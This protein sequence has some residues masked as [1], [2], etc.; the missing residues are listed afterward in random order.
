MNED[1][2]TSTTDWTEEQLW[3]AVQQRDARF[4]GRM[5]YAVRSTGIYCKPTCPS[6]RPLR[7]NVFFFQTI[8]EADAAGFRPC[9]R[10]HPEET[11]AQ[12]EQVALARRACA[13][14]DASPEQPPSLEVLS[15]EL[16]L[17]PSYLQ[18]IFKSVLG[19]SPRQ[20]AANQKL[21]AFK[22]HI[23]AGSDVTTAMYAAGYSSTSRLYE[24]VTQRMG[25]TPASYRQGG[26]GKQIHFTF[27]QTY[28]G[29]ML[30][31][32]T[33]KG[34]CRVSF[35]QDEPGMVTL[36]RTE[37]PAAELLQDDTNLAA[38]V[39]MLVKH[40]EGSQ[41]HLALPLDLQATAFQLRVWEE[42]R[43]IPYGQTRTYAEVAQAVGKPRAVRAVANACAA[44]PVVVVTPCHRVVRSDGSLG[45]YRYGVE[46]KQA[47]LSQEQDHLN[48]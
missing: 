36:L 33:D 47:L 46:R 24:G 2:L 28:L 34:I 9:R 11:L 31:A 16:H 37:Y 45:G 3:Q 40:L 35:G 21:T 48:D 14:I 23:R 7:E 18:R 29:K 27:V 10:C 25:M 6:R 30:V 1:N 12:D 15:R 26:A 17:S 13:L 41:P 44:N 22:R 39:N 42:L 38:A 20:Y 19:F 32:G 4:V 43:R 5:V 8:N